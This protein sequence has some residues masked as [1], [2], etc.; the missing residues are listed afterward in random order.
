M[1][2]LRVAVKALLVAAA[3]GLADAS[4]HG[5][6]PVEKVITLLEDLKSQITGE[7]Q[8][9]ATT[10]D[11]FSCFCKDTTGLK[12]TS[13]TDGQDNI[14]QLSANI[15]ADTA[16]KA[17]KATE[18]MERKKTQEEHSADLTAETV[19]CQ[20][21]AA[22]FEAQTM[23][24]T[25]AVSSLG[26]AVTALENANSQPT[27]T[28][29]L[30]VKGE[31]ADSLAL[32]DALSLIPA[33]KQHAV[34]AFLQGA[35]VD[36]LDPAY[37]FRSQGILDTIKQ[38]HVDF[39]DKKTQVEE[40]AGKAHTVCEDA[41]AALVAL[42]DSN[43]LAMEGLK[44]DID[45]LETTI[46]T[47]RESL[48]TAEGNLKNDQLYLKDLTERCEKGA[49]D[50][51]QR[52]SLRANEIQALTE[53]LTIIKEG[54]DGRASV[55][56]LDAVNNRSFV[57]EAAAATK[58]RA[59]QEAELRAAPSLI[60]GAARRVLARSHNLRGGT[61]SMMAVA[62]RAAQ[63]GQDEAVTTLKSEGIRLKSEMLSSLAAKVA[64][65]PFAKVKN[66]I[67][68]LIER[69]LDESKQEATKKGFCDT[70]IGKAT[71]TRDFKFEDTKKLAAEL[72]MLEVKRDELDNTITTLS[73]NIVTLNGVLNTTT[74]Q[75]GTEKAQ[76]LESIRTAK[77]GVEAVSE[78]ITIL[79]VFYKKAGK[80]TVLTQASPVDAET[81][82]PGF[83]GAYR[84]GQE[85]AT[86]IIG[87]LEV[88]KSDFDRTVRMTELAEN[89]AH[90]DF[91]EF[92]RTSRSDI[93]GKE[94]TV[95]LSQQDLR[96]TNSAIDRK[97]GDLTT[98]QGL[99]DDA[100]KT[101]EDLKPM[102]IDTGMSYTERVGKRAEEIAALKTALC[103]LDPND[104]EA[105]CGG[106]R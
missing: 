30:Q 32:A 96:A 17:G 78:A 46:S 73:D 16:A 72:S 49:K 42:L 50:W 43:S 54:K 37:K 33:H 34:Q 45:G 66:L 47:S 101:I 58:A 51:D 80:A 102:C 4:S 40:E 5:V 69:L 8:A 10:Y 38:L 35:K 74:E 84:G 79:K 94:T 90:A 13:I 71:T 39:T 88:I 7:G 98:S 48:V 29:L 28:V 91:V 85:S 36:P 89:Q 23:D 1:A 9:E 20:A 60:Q 92:D 52:S 81:S 83:S 63:W 93:K 67:Q 41:K 19:R 76:N 77:E 59:V 14:D 6:T 75:R 57:Q 24:L 106:G 103:Q 68:Q 3:A 44:T 70:E 104:V 18:L 99:L 2:A 86:G 21:E 11:E 105:E 65:D 55:Q 62:V 61:R 27:S 100:L 12:S 97:M 15:E 31:I 26:K 64:A 56:E 53:A 95:E 87:M 25:K 82:G 22:E